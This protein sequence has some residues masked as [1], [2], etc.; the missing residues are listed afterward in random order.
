[1]LPF[2]GGDVWAEAD[3]DG[4]RL[5]ATE[6]RDST[7]PGMRAA[8]WDLRDPASPREFELPSDRVAHV[9]VS[10]DGRKLTLLE[11]DE[12]TEDKTLQVWD[13]GDGDPRRGATMRVPG[14]FLEVAI[15]NDGQRLALRSASRI[16]VWD[17]SVDPPQ[18]RV[19][20]P[21]VPGDF[22]AQFAFS[23][24]D[25]QIAVLGK[26]AVEVWD[27]GGEGEAVN[28]G[29]FGAF[30]GP[31]ALRYR[32]REKAFAVIDGGQSTWTLGT[33]LEKVRN[34]L[35]RERSVALTDDEWRRYFPDVARVSV[36]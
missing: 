8:I 21:R 29:S 31:D 15:S 16:D 17:M 25:R 1:V 6:R 28:A 3:R 13:V 30:R 34:G 11:R 19:A 14:E 32:T 4:T 12:G 5:V 18:V 35:C 2:G 9:E 20:V 22:T 36:C 23:A 24:D 33:D 26:N 10:P 27:V 7:G